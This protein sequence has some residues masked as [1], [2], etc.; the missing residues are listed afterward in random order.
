MATATR[1][2]TSVKPLC[3][4]AAPLPISDARRMRI[5]F[6]ASPGVFRPAAPRA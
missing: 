4:A 1:I 6:E 3:E 2:S 5:T